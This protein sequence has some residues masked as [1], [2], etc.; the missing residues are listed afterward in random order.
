MQIIEVKQQ[1]ITGEGHAVKSKVTQEA[2]G[3]IV[4]LTVITSAVTG[5]P[6]TEITFKDA[7]GCIIIPDAAFATL[8]DD[9]EHIFFFLSEQGT[10]DAT[11]NPVPVR[12]RLTVTVNPSADP[13]GSGETFTVKVRIFVRQD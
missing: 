10:Q 6:T 13:G 11:E 5:N 7:D 9:S 3:T 8:A 4:G 1:W 2:D 12:G